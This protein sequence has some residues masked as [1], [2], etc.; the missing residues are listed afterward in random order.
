MKQFNILFIALT[1][2]FGILPTNANENQAKEYPIGKPGSQLTYISK[3]K[4]LPASVIRKFELSLG[5][6][7]EKNGTSHQWLRLDAVKENGQTYSIHFLTTEY[8]SEILRAMG[9]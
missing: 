5:A 9:R 2:V 3:V 7:E 8:P 6:I 1:F 4:E